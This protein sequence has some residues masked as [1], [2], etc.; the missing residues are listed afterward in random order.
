MDATEFS[1]FLATVH[2]YDTFGPEEAARVARLFRPVEIA[3][4]DPVYE[5]GMPLD[6]LFLIDS[7]QVTVT[8]ATG[9]HLSSLSRGNTLGERGLLL[10]G[11]AVTSAKAET[12]ARLWILPSAEFHRLRKAWPTFER[13][14][15][16]GRRRARPARRTDLAQMTVAE[17]MTES[18][19]TC[20]PEAKAVDAARQMRDGRFSSIC[21]TDASRRLIGIVTLRDLSGRVLAEGLSNDTPVASVMTPDPLTLPPD[22]I[23]SDVL[24]LM[25]ERDIG[26]IPVT[27]DGELRGI[28][29]QTD[30]TR[31]QAMNSSYL[32]GEIARA[33]SADA[34]ARL[35]ARIP[36]LLAQLVGSGSRHDM[37]TRLVT[38]VADAVTRRLIVLAQEAL[39]TPPVPFLWLACGS[40]GRR[41]QTGTSDQ[42]NCL[43][44]GD[45]ATADDMTYFTAFA[46]SV[47]DGLDAA[48]YVHCPGDMMASNPRWCQPLSVWRD[49]FRR[50]I[51]TPSP[52][53]QMLA[54]VM[55]DLRVIEGP[56]ESMF[57]TLQGE[58]LDAAS[59]NSIFAA[60]MVANSLKHRPP[61][62][63]IRGFTTLRSGVHRNTIDMKAN[64]V[65]PVT[66][67]ARLY[68]LM[69]AL[70][71]VN[72]R[73]RIEAA[74]G[75]G[76]VS[77]SGARDLL[78][79][80][81]VI[82]EARLKHQARQVVEGGGPDNFLPPSELSDFERSH[83]RDAFV[84]VRTMQSAVGQGRGT[85][86]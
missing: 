21:V 26:H 27:S 3:A 23:G 54:S 30:L 22:A 42:D 83:L 11:I 32:V 20:P 70:R 25:M 12:A 38:D 39:G 31:R 80:Y 36:E 5:L 85:L 59:G 67:L 33:A 82:A 19:S 34:I 81:D 57:G 49:Y 48:G 60:H 77:T 56:G 37:V 75:T 62:G 2:P 7:G 68:A 47:T 4:G 71:P 28:V 52:E 84:V 63:L 24:N 15:V 72:T 55:F 10:D 43:I 9:A 73:E 17:I 50:W 13:F 65:V 16:R 35:T 76:A 53:A 29:T 18:P 41:E 8:D 61:L 64:G 86:I 58:T 74:A 45:A 79:A 69:S 66:D 78:D 44:I 51:E 14:F 1:H 6:G 46:K 40:Q